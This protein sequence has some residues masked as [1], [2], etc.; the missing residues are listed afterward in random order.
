M[1]ELHDAI[2]DAQYIGAVTNSQRGPSAAF[3]NPSRNELTQFMKIQKQQHRS[4]KKLNFLIEVTKFRLLQTAE[5][6]AVKG[7]EIWDLFIGNATTEGDSNTTPRQHGFTIWSPD[8]RRDAGRLVSPPS[9]LSTSAETDYL[10]TCT[11]LH[12]P[13]VSR[14][15]SSQTSVGFL[16]DLS[17]ASKTTNGIVFWR[18]NESSVTRENARSMFSVVATD[19][20]A[21]GVGGEVVHRLSAV[22]KCKQSVLE[23][24]VD[25]RDLL[26]CVRDVSLPACPTAST[27][28]LSEPNDLGLKNS[29]ENLAFKTRSHKRLNVDFSVFAVTL[30]DELEACVLCSL[31]Q[32]DLNAFRASAFYTRLITF[33]FVQKRRVSKDDFSLLRVLGRGGFGMVNGC[34]KR[35]SASLYAMKVMNKKMI[36]K[37]HAEKMCLAERKI[38]T[39]ISSPFVVCLKYSF[40]TPEELFLVLDLRTGGDLSFHLNRARFSETQVRFWAA[41]ILL[42]IQ[43]LHEKNI[44]YRDLKPENILL[45][46][47][48]NCSLSDLGLAVEKTATLTGRCGTRGYWAPEMLLRDE[49]GNRLVYNQM[50]DWWSYGCLVYEL[51]YGKCPFRTSK[52][53]ALHE[54]KQQAYDKATLELIPSYDSRYFSA[55]AVDLIQQLLVR[56]PNQRL[57][58]KGAEEIKSMRF[59]SSIDWP[60]MELMQVPPPFVPNN[61][62]NAASQSDIGSFDI[63][64]VK[65]I[66]LSEQEQAAYSD[67]DYVCH[68]TFQ[69]EAVEY[70]VWEAKNGPCTIGIHNHDSCC[71]IL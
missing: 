59:F 52:A 33:L 6:R 38:L 69:R 60:Q 62:I 34:I 30:F 14:P 5:Q 54:D 44:V 40:Q 68:E 46:E 4:C 18:K 21:L 49:D 51:L 48:G 56:D 50:V 58:A 43:H 11:V 28:S 12:S 20:H 31:E 10:S 45:D 61:E 57:G 1:D 67:W 70:L 23:P 3:Y 53:K 27:V 37:R 13:P 71:L 19:A 16:D 66:K 39:M 17:V 35:T 32:Y 15:C 24:D 47:K 55:D 42:G 8:R 2:Q 36:K 7:R 22:F 64:A 29:M 63:S 65:G 9:S 41:Q 26:D 25:R